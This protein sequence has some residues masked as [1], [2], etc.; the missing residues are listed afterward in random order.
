MMMPCCLKH[1]GLKPQL[2][3]VSRHMHYN[4]FQYVVSTLATYVQDYRTIELLFK[5]SNNSGLEANASLAS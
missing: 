2:L 3:P 5:A 1:A 4:F